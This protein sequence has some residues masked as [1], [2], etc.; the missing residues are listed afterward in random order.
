MIMAIQSITLDEVDYYMGGKTE[1][2]QPHTGVFKNCRGEFSVQ[3]LGETLTEQD[4][5]IML[6]EKYLLCEIAFETIELF[7][8]RFY[9]VWNE[10][11]NILKQNLQN[12]E[13]FVIDES[14][15]TVTENLKVDR[16]ANNTA[17]NS[18][19]GE[20]DNTI[21]SDSKFSDTPNQYVQGQ[22]NGLTSISVR[23]DTGKQTYKDN[24]LLTAETTGKDTS[25]RD[26]T[27]T[28]S[29]NAFEKWLSLS[30]RN[31]NIIY[32]FIAKFDK[33]FNKTFVLKNYDRWYFYD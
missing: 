21:N 25:T 28:H 16:T 13:E 2:R 29:I 10:N 22:F 4:I 3:Y 30:E 14:K 12:V 1:N 9:N 32:S 7:H 23:D 11:F 17:N 20:N 8:W 19:T 15:E 33:L 24:T 31:Y 26:F 6:L 5:E 27:R 18:K